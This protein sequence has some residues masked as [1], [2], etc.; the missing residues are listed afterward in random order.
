[1]KVDS[2]TLF[3]HKFEVMTEIGVHAFEVGRTQR[4]LIDVEMTIGLDPQH[5]E[6]SL[7]STVDYDFLRKEIR[8]LASQ[9]RFNTQEALCIAVLDIIFDHPHITAAKVTTRKPDVYPDAEAVGCCI[10]ARA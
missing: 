3:L 6:D 4:V 1:M 10:E 5:R 2:L 8:D 7:K 9:R